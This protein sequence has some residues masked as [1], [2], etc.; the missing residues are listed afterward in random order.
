MVKLSETSRLSPIPWV[1]GGSVVAGRLKCG[2]EVARDLSNQLLPCGALL[3]PEVLDSY[4]INYNS[5]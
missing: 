2:A 5:S 4:K 3:K 1:R